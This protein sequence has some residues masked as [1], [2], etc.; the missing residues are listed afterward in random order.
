VV[1][2]EA[3]CDN[4]RRTTSFPGWVSFRFCLQP[5]YRLELTFADS[6]LTTLNSTFAHSDPIYQVD[7]R[8]LI[9]FK[10]CSEVA[11]QIDSLVQFSPT[12]NVKLRKGGVLDFVEL[13]LRESICKDFLVQVREVRST[14]LGGQ[15]KVMVEHRAR[16]RALGIPWSPQRRK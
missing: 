3:R 8:P 10:Q 1:H 16:M 15:E 11:E 2:T 5:C 7:G 9:D 12:H 6:H 4:W 14:E 13:S